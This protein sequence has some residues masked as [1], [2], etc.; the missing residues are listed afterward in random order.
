MKSSR[1]W[2]SILLPIAT[3]SPV[4]AQSTAAAPAGASTQAAGDAA[5]TGP[6]KVP[7]TRAVGN[8]TPAPTTNESTMTRYRPEAGLFELGIFGGAMF[9]SDS[10]ALEGS[11]VAHREFGTGGELGLRLAAFPIHFLGIE[12]EAATVAASV[13]N[14]GG[15]GIWAGRGHFIGQLTSSSITPF[16][17]VGVGALGANSKEMGRDT[18]FG[19][20]FGAGVKLPFDDFLSARLDMRDTM[21]KASS[22]TSASIAHSPEILLRINLHIGKI[23]AHSRQ[24]RCTRRFGWRRHTGCK[25]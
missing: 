3:V 15:A 17:L 20:H 12:A 14:G 6:D 1:F 23:K 7:A 2:L 13:K 8:T 18:D 5:P 21:T 19:F 10:H 11:G 25:R 16:L 9:P 22:Q 4:L 24:S